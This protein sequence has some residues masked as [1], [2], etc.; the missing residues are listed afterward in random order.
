MEILGTGSFGDGIKTLGKNVVA[1][2]IILVEF[3]KPEER[4][5]C[6]VLNHIKLQKIFE[7]IYTPESKN[8]CYVMEEHKIS[9]LETTEEEY[10]LVAKMA[11]QRI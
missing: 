2:K 6:L 9:L 8:Y 4:L 11:L 7:V 10:E 3:T 1:V 5:F